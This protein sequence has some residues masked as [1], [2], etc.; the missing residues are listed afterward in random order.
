MRPKVE[1]YAATLR[2]MAASKLD[3]NISVKLTMLGLGYPVTKSHL[4]TC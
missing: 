1:S 2:E 3:P 4:T